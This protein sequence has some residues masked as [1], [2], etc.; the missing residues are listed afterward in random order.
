M[1]V[2]KGKVGV[3]GRLSLG[4]LQVR[5]TADDLTRFR[6]R[7]VAPDQG[8]VG[9]KPLSSKQHCVGLYIVFFLNRRPSSVIDIKLEKPPDQP[10]SEGGCAC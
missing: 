7:G 4:R 6:D 2:I 1:R 3:R 9:S 5:L 10:V 8:V